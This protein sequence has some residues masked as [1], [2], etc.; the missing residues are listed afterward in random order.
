MPLPPKTKHSLVELKGEL[1]IQF[2]STLIQI[3]GKLSKQYVDT[4]PPILY[5]KN[6]KHN[7]HGK[8]SCFS[9]FVLELGEFNKNQLSMTEGY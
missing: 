2:F 8:Q 1:L 5:Y 7:I 4:P 9:Y 6:R 3:W